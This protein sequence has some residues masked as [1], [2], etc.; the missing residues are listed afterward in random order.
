MARRHWDAQQIG[1][2][3]LGG[4][5]GVGPNEPPR[6]MGVVL[7]QHGHFRRERVGLGGFRTTFGGGES[8]KRSGVALAAPV[9]QG[10]RVNSLA[11]KD[12]ADIA[13]SGGLISRGEDAQLVPRG[14]RPPARAGR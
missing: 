6:E 8:V 7:L 14:E 1:K 9:T 3:F 2:L 5:D 10:R 12:R 13:G 11:A 4:D